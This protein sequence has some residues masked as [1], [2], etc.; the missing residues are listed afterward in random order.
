MYAV[1]WFSAGS[2]PLMCINTAAKQNEPLFITHLY[3]RG[4][5]R[6]GPMFGRA[7]PF[8]LL[9]DEA[10]SGCVLH[11]HG[12]L[13][14]QKRRPLKQDLVNKW[15]ESSWT[16]QRSYLKVKKSSTLCLHDRHKPAFW[17]TCASPF[18]E[19]KHHKHKKPQKWKKWGCHD[20]SGTWEPQ[21]MAF[22]WKEVDACQGRKIFIS[23]ISNKQNNVQ[24]ILH[25]C[26]IILHIFLVISNSIAKSPLTEIRFQ[27]FPSYMSRLCF[28]CNW[29]SVV[30]RYLG[31]D[32]SYPIIKGFF[33][34]SMKISFYKCSKLCPWLF[35]WLRIFL[36]RVW[37]RDLYHFLPLKTL[38]TLTLDE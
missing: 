22:I 10:S 28:S 32:F 14:L 34:K 31:H 2:W 37:G 5:I 12:A 35:T 1:A 30:E 17:F 23:S 33:H 24:L 19:V 20:S 9:T 38:Q 27:K 8:V 36:N 16:Q 21:Y 18:A 15:D 6:D 26:R 4:G 13:R 29:E 7:S 3:K 25:Y 11:L